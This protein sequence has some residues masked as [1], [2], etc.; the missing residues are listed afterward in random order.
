M[1]AEL[2]AKTAEIVK[3]AEKLLVRVQSDSI[4]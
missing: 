1:N 4:C 2:E 3:E